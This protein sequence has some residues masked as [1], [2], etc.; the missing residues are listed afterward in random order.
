MNRARLLL[1]HSPLTD[2]LTLFGHGDDG[3]LTLVR[4][5]C[6]VFLRRTQGGL[7]LQ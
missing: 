4:E 3:L 2:R 6:S 5:L 1:F 7:P